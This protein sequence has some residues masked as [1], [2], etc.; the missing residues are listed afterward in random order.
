MLLLNL[1][2]GNTVNHAKNHALLY[3][4]APRITRRSKMW[5][6]IWSW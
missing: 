5:R 1:L 6:R 4:G 2:P 3:H